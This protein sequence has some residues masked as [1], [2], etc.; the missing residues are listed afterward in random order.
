[1]KDKVIKIKSEKEKSSKKEEKNPKDGFTIDTYKVMEDVLFSIY[2]A[3]DSNEL[4][5]RGLLEILGIKIEGDI[6]SVDTNIPP[7][8]KGK[9]GSIFD[10]HL[11]TSCNKKIDIEVQQEYEKYFE[12]RLIYYL[13]KMITLTINR[14]KNNK[15]S[16]KAK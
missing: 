15:I 16:E 5:Q 4:Q 8:I 2:M 14:G 9:K 12:D 6:K 1:M 3:S 10:C 13:S 11:R 7:D